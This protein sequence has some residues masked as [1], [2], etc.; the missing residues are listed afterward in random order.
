MYL[1]HVPVPWTSGV[2][3]QP[4]VSQFKASFLTD[5]SLCTGSLSTFKGLFLGLRTSLVGR[6]GEEITSLFLNTR[7]YCKNLIYIVGWLLGPGRPDELGPDRD[8]HNWD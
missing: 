5:T 1:E 3:P 2:D 8:C 6:I 4:V 7:R